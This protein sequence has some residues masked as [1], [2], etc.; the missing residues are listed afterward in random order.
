MNNSPTNRGSCK[1]QFRSKCIA[2]IK[3]I[4]EIHFRHCRHRVRRIIIKTICIYIR[5]KGTVRVSVET[6]VK[7]TRATSRT[8]I[9]G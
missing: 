6:K 7:Q 2:L 5:I 1:H 4:L 9:K 3:R 8:Y